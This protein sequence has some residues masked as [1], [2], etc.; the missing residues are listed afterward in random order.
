MTSAQP[1]KLKLVY[2]VTQAEWGGAQRYI[3]DLATALKDGFEII[4]ATGAGG[5]SR[6]LQKCQEA[7]IRTHTFKNLVRKINPLKDFAAVR[8][9]TDFFVKESPDIIHLNSSKAGIIGS[10]ACR[11]LQAKNYKLKAKIVYTAH[12][13]VFEEPLPL[14]RKQLYVL[15]ERIACKIHHK[16]IVLS[17]ADFDT[18]VKNK[19]CAPEK[20]TIIPHG[21]KQIDFSSRE[22][23]RED[24]AKRYTLY[25]KRS[26]LWIVTIA[27][28]YKTKGINY[29]ID[30]AA[31]LKKD[32][33]EPNF[34]IIGSGS[35]E[36]SY[37]LKTISYKLKSF[38]FVGSI[39]DAARYLKAFDIFVLPSVK[40]GMPYALLEA[41]QAGLPIITTSVGAIPEML[42]NEMNGLIVPPTNS[43]ILAE[44]IQRL[45]RN[46]DL[47]ENLSQRVALEFQEKF[48]FEKMLGKT[49]QIYQ[50]LL[51]FE[52]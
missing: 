5:S 50:N 51:R 3:F 36:V 40:E 41:M 35:M 7:S 30:A 10:L 29:L 49:S 18:A 34:I 11:K 33:L 6:L 12:G 28:L 22:Q 14:W 19:L 45:L 47:R 20:M 44:A 38:H 9:L 15:I 25:A 26:D 24:L 37:K 1:S 13:W 16:V 43:R 17:K 2:I 46:H 42:E 27:N 21:I 39:P 23:A 32:G 4:V 31:L 52:N 48:S 8:E